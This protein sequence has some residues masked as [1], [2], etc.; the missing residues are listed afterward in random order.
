MVLEGSEFRKNTSGYNLVYQLKKGN[1]LYTLKGTADLNG[2]I[3]TLEIPPENTPWIPAL[4]VIGII[5]LF[6]AILWHLKR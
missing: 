5:I 2:S 3:L 1:V 6:G 4:L